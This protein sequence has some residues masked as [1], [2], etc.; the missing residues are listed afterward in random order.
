MLFLNYKYEN[1]NNVDVHQNII[2]NYRN[3]FKIPFDSTI[4]IFIFF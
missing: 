2:D 4:S 3:N 1:W